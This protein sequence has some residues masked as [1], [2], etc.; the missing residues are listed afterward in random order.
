MRSTIA[1]CSVT[2]FVS[3]S[4]KLPIVSQMPRRRKRQVLG[5]RPIV[6]DQQFV[7][8]SVRIGPGVHAGIA[9]LRQQLP[10]GGQ[11]EFVE[12]TPTD[13]QQG[14]RHGDQPQKR[15]GQRDVRINERRAIG[16][17]LVDAHDLHH[18]Q[19]IN[20]ADR[21]VQHTDEQ[22]EEQEESARLLRSPTKRSPAGQRSP[23]SRQ[24]PKTAAGR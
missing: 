7:Q 2:M 14:G 1:F 10:R 22:R 19:V 16:R 17:G 13:D 9:F 18:S 21:R 23:V 11:G 24:S 4:R 15:A 8:N 5:Q 20:Q 6:Q 12:P 3:T